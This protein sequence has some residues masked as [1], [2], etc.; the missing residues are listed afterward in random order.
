MASP[1]HLVSLRLVK[2]Y[3]GYK[4]GEVIQATPR[5]A[6]E[7]ERLGVAVGD[8]ARPLLE[9]QRAERAV[10]THQAVEAR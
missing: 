2:A 4:S 3:R 10:A 5:L 8:A 6:A 9:P 7:L 1:V